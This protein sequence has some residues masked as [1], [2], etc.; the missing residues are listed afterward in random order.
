MKKIFK[1]REWIVSINSKIFPLR[2]VSL[3]LSKTKPNLYWVSP[4][5]R[6]YY[7]IIPLAE[8]IPAKP[9]ITQQHVLRAVE[10]PQ[11]MLGIVHFGQ[12]PESG[13]LET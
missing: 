1:T 4:G 5:P 7:L 10:T 9:M 2:M 11:T 3:S 6:I 12:Y 13:R 8:C